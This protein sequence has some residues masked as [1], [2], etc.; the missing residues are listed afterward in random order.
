MTR[1]KF[2]W[3]ALGVLLATPYVLLFAAGSVWLYERG[4]LLGYMAATVAVTAAAL[5]VMHGMRVLARRRAASGDTPVP[6]GFPRGGEPDPHWPPLARRAWDEVEAIARRVE[7]EDLPLDQPE[8]IG[9]LF[10]EV[11][12]AVARQY[13]PQAAEPELET[14][15]P[16]VL[17]AVERVARDLR[18]AFSEN[19]PGAHVLTLGDFWRLKRLAQW[20]R[21]AYFLYRLAAAG[22][23]PVSALMRE[24]RDAAADKMLASST[25][26]LKQW[27]VGYCTRRA[28]WYAIEL[29]SQTRDWDQAALEAFRTPESRR[30]AEQAAART[31]PLTAEPLRILV[32]GQV[33]SGK[34]SVINAL[35]GEVRSAVDVV[36]CTRNVEPYLLEREG[37]PLALVLDT[38]GYESVDA[39]EPLSPVEKEMLRCD[40]VL[41][42]LTAVSAARQADRR[43]LDQLREF[44]RKHPERTMPP[45]V[46]VLTHIDLVRPAGEW[47][48][49]YDLAHPKDAKAAHIAEAVRAVAEDLALSDAEPVVPV[50]LK[51]Q[52]EYN[53]EEGLVP[54]IL[55]LLPK[56]KAA[57]YLRCLRRFREA[58]HWRRL[59]RQTLN[60]GSLLWHVGKSWLARRKG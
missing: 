21:Q 5:G 15:L 13:H 46:V 54:A 3:L 38:A 17:W 44:Y 40:L 22:F 23:N 27:A 14:P 56:A 48:P 18:E 36:P 1:W 12:R 53:V 20:Y 51:P 16:Q 60:A 24:I 8:R 19:V 45:V 42:V 47:N 39:V 26:D 9:Q 58:T 30:D 11:L 49:P 2:W 57:C 25:G 55:E 4:L 41:L 35:F 52:A 29:Y 28:G 34:S 7:R 6:L 31:A 43:L 50:C 33:K 10:L 37:M 32:A 59:W